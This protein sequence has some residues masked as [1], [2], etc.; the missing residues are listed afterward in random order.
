MGYCNGTFKEV[1]STHENKRTQKRAG[2]RAS[3]PHRQH[4]H[5]LGQPIF[6][7]LPADIGRRAYRHPVGDAF[8]QHAVEP[9]GIEPRNEIF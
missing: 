2:R 9:A 7:P 5:L 3:R 4:P 8:G 6:G 1:I